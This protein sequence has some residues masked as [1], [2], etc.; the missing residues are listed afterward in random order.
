MFR[1]FLPVVSLAL[2]FAACSDDASGTPDA[3]PLPDF[4][5]SV[6]YDGSVA[7]A[8]GSDAAGSDA[9]S[10]D[11]GPPLDIAD[12]L[13]LIDGMTVTELSSD[14][15]GYRL[16]VLDYIQPADHNAPA[17]QTF[18]QQITLLHRDS[19]AP[20]VLATTGYHNYFWAYRVEP[21]RMLH[22]NQLLVEQRY[23]AG[24]R[25]IPTNWDL[26][27]IW[28]A[29]TDHHRLVEALKPIYT[30]SWVSTGASK[31]GMTSIYHRRWYPD[32]VDATIAYVAPISFGIPDASYTA[33]F[34]SVGD[35]AC[36]QAVRD[37]QRDVLERRPAL[38]TM[39]TDYIA[40]TGETYT[41]IGSPAAA[42]EDDIAGFE[43]SFWQYMGDAW[44]S[45]IPPDTATDQEVFDFLRDYAGIGGASDQ[46][47]ELFQ[48]YYVQA[49]A[50]LG[51]PAGPS[52]AHISDLYQYSFE[53]S[54]LPE[55]TIVDF[56]PNA[57]VDIQAWVSSSASRL[58]LIYG[59]YDPWTAGAFDLGNASDSHVFTVPL[60]NHGASIAAL[61][62]TERDQAMAIIGGWMNVVP[63]LPSSATG[64]PIIVPEQRRTP[65]PRWS[66]L[67]E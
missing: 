63:Q 58:M 45:F 34:D 48:P 12:Q 28:Q 65:P 11:A 16:F 38:E 54:V 61:P 55:N 37:F 42:F 9:A 30:G 59:Q 53:G 64:T 7:D 47:I 33:F 39:A 18:S 36:R 56:D 2:L 25:P 40:T 14:E 1:Q 17:G 27:R 26:L 29:A 6:T 51:F 32:D 67:M 49:Y 31:G 24:S 52:D 8:S 44:C 3:G 60:A 13:A 15:P 22:A 43:W 4:D 5:A 66:K 19:A 41:I 10:Y 35:P 20:M 62:V 46:A 57:M 21:T 23:F 50:E